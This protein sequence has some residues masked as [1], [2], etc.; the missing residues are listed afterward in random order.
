MKKKKE[1]FS[2]F[3]SDPKTLVFGERFFPFL[4]KND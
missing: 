3:F 1:N 2:H 4:V